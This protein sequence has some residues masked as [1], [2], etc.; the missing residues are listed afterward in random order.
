MVAR[1]TIRG[2]PTAP[3]GVTTGI[4]SRADAVGGA[5]GIIE[6][7]AAR[8]AVRADGAANRIARTAA[9][10]TACHQTD[11]A[12]INGRT[13]IAAAAITMPLARRT[14][15]TKI[16]VVPAFVFHA[17][18]AHTAI[19]VLIAGRIFDEVWEANRVVV[20]LACDLLTGGLA[21][22]TAPLSGA[23]AFG[24]TT[25]KTLGAKTASIGRLGGKTRARTKGALT[26]IEHT[27]ITGAAHITPITAATWK[28]RDA[29]LA[30]ITGGRT[31][32]TARAVVPA[33]TSARAE[34][35]HGLTLRCNP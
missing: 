15:G 19:T 30:E 26:A 6:T 23:A 5:L 18:T 7:K 8:A 32:P 27:H 29:N 9:V 17:N 33:F 31:N 2:H 12:A 16:G 34:V 25:V 28:S 4:V 3:L 24:A 10:G 20:T 1:R 22:A 35:A 14:S 21:A 11:I 13:P